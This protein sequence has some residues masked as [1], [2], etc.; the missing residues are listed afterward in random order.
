MRNVLLI[1]PSWVGL[2]NDIIN[3]LQRMEYY[4]EFIPEYSFLKDPYKVEHRRRPLSQNAADVQKTEYWQRN[5]EK[6]NTVF[7]VL[8]VIDGQGVNQYLFD[9]LLRRNPQVRS[10]N[11]LYDTT[12]SLYHFERNFHFFNHVFT[13]DKKDASNYQIDHLPI[14]WTESIPTNKAKETYQVFGFG[15]YSENRYRLYKQIRAIARE[16]NKS[17][18]IKLY[19]PRAKTFCPYKMIDTIRHLLGRKRLIPYNIYSSDYITSETMSTDE[20]RHYVQSSDV[21][22]DTKVNDQ[23]GLTARFM[24]ALGAGKKI[25]TTNDSVKSYDFYDPLQILVVEDKKFDDGEK[26]KISQFIANEYKM[27]LA[28]MDILIRYR[29]DFWLKTIINV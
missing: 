7:D 16:M 24:W 13:F 28:K 8:L 2:H 21:V 5:L 6:T 27:Q 10:V 26:E 29:V 14:Y 11:Y 19:A 1:A 4:V 20:F 18:F 15:A 9:E 22:L 23:D 25:I 12:Y 17:Y 3:E